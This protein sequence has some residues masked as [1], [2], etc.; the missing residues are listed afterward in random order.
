MTKRLPA[1]AEKS[2]AASSTSTSSGRW[3]ES[4]GASAPQGPIQTPLIAGEGWPGVGAGPSEGAARRAKSRREEMSPLWNVCPGESARVERHASNQ[5]SESSHAVASAVDTWR[6]A[7]QRSCGVGAKLMSP[8][9]RGWSPLSRH[10][11]HSAV[12]IER[13][14]SWRAPTPPV[15]G[16]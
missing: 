15:A 1:V 7:A 14:A 3:S 9:N 13:K 12:A 6:D 10:S 8:R 4:A 16:A 11:R 5:R 2:H